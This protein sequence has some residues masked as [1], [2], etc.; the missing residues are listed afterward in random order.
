[1]SFVAIEFSPLTPEEEAW[2]DQVL[3]EAKPPPPREERIKLTREEK[4]LFLAILDD[5]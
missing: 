4:D 1:M 5:L 2:R 3:A